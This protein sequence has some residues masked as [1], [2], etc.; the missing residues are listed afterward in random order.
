MKLSRWTTLIVFGALLLPLRAEPPAKDAVTKAQKQ[1]PKEQGARMV[2]KQ[3]SVT[4]EGKQIDYTVRTSR[5]VLKK[6][7]GKARASV[8][9]VAYIRNGVKDVSKRPVLFAFNGGPG[10]SAVWLHLG[11]LG[12]RIVPTS[13]DGTEALKPPLTVKENPFS[14]LDVADL[15][16]I[17]PVSTGYSRSEDSKERFHGVDEDIES[18]GDFIRRWITENK[19][20]SSPKYILGESYGGVRAAGLAQHL[21]SRYGMTLNGVVLLSGLM[22]FST[23][24]PGDGNDLAYIAY[25]PAYTAIAHYHG[26]LKGDRDTLVKNAREFAAGPYATALLK[27]YTLDDASR[28]KVAAELAALT[29]LP[30]ELV[31][32]YD[33][34]INPSRFRKDLLRSEN[35]VLGRFD[36]RTAWPVQDK[37]GDFPSYDPS[38]SVAMGAFSTAMLGYLADGLGWLDDRPYEII[39]Q[40]GAWNWGKKNGFVNMA[41]RL[42]AAMRDNPHLRVLVQCGHA[43]LATPAGG[44]LHT[45]AHMNVPAPQRKNISVAWYDAGH[46]FYLNQPDLEKMRK[47]LVAFLNPEN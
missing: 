1:N 33:L 2:E 7:D 44:I 6:E 12:P 11:A 40:V 43:D 4:I 25:L 47:D 41:P 46:M 18:V 17:D 36:A 10:S 31:L 23:L 37:A 29:S 34:R 26:K 28:K 38:M 24:N 22:D 19:R 32:R 27:G 13:A 9:N 39:A 8:F 42:A 14:I 30:E 3:A 35:K 21:Q 16:F 45:V 5:L 20:W 15:V